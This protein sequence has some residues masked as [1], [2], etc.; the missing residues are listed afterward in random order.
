MRGYEKTTK[1]LT[2]NKGKLELLAKKLEEEEVLEGEQVLELL[3][4]EKKR[5]RTHKEA[6][7]TPIEQPQQNLQFIN[8]EPDKT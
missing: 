2:D 1:L 8:K 7:I 6:D 4:I 3:N 5:P